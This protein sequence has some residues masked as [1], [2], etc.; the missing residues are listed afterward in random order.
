VADSNDLETRPWL[1]VSSPNFHIK[2]TLS[3]DRTVELLRHLEIMHATLGTAV[4]ASSKSKPTIIL[5]VDS[6]DDYVRIG[7]PSYS[8]GFFF[9]DLRESAILIEDS[10]ESQG[11][12]VILHEYVHYLN[13]QSGRFRY[14][15]WYEEGN[16]EYLSHS[17]FHDQT[18][19]Y[20]LAPSQH[21]AI[22]SVS[23][24]LPLTTLLEVSDT[25][26]LVKEDGAMF[27]AQSW[28]L[29]HY[30]KSLPDADRNL[31]E[32]LAQFAQL[33][34]SGLPPAA[35]FERAFGVELE[36]LETD[37][38]AYFLNRR[39]A[40]RSLP[41]NT[42]LSGF[43]P[44]VRTMSPAET[45]LTLARMAL[46]FENTLGAEE[47]FKMVIRDNELRAYAEAGL[48][49]IEG[50]RGDVEAASERFES[51]IYLMAWD[52]NIWM[53]Y[54]QYWAQRVSTT[55]DAKERNT[56]VVRL[57]ESL[58]NALTVS[59]ATPELNSLMGFAYLA[60]GKNRK[61]SIE[62]LEAAASVAP[63]DQASRLLLA[64]AYMFAGRTSDAISTAQAVLRFEHEPN[65]VTSAANELIAE[66]RRG[67]R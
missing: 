28:L 35:T 63:C 29:V 6:H 20:A 30:L 66:A 58:E 15:R 27:Y 19:E 21:L 24:W 59:E 56:Y 2:S 57:I 47:W 32:Q 36:Q 55:K 17:R 43:I 31:P 50:L 9:A 52:F 16:A 5:A 39:F 61:E 4:K 53:D 45:H 11:V 37:L 60:N 34:S 25:S 41:A 26:S 33:A 18:F 14:P 48:G 7:A 62:Y 67:R 23:N 65:L 22:L 64:N 12:Q 54:A 42:A 40:S 49:R 51:A 38:L 8:A 46:R 3:E 13:R 10:D 1:E 44:T